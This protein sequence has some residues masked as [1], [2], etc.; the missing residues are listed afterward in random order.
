MNKGE[1]Y[2]VI[3]EKTGSTEKDAKKFLQAFLDTVTETL[4]KGGEIPLVGFGTFKTSKRKARMGKN[5]ATG[6]DIE[7]PAM[8]LPVFKAGKNLKNAVNHREGE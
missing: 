3:A 6:E 8:T 2:K 4:V 5:M 7:V 1:L